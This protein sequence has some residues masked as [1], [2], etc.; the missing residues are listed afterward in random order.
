MLKKNIEHEITN[1]YENLASG[2][3]NQIIFE[4]KNKI[5]ISKKL[6]NLNLNF[7]LKNLFKDIAIKQIIITK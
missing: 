6:L 1:P 3:T 7:F 2:A 4:I 5:R